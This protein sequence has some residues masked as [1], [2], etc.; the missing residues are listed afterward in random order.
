MNEYSVM[1]FF[2]SVFGG[3]NKNEKIKIKYKNNLKLS[4]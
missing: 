1:N 4:C 3:D 2:V